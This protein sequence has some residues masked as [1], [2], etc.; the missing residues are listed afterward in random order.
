MAVI[1]LK[2]VTKVFGTGSAQ[3]KALKDVNF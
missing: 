3:V 1:E 2:D